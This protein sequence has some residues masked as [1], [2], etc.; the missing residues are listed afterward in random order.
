MLQVILETLWFFLPAMVANMAPVFVAKYK[1][2]E[3]LNYSIDG[4]ATFRGK[5]LFGD[6]KTVR[7]FVVGVAIALLTG[8]MQYFLFQYE[9]VT[10]I[11]IMSYSSILFVLGVSFLLGFGALVGD[12]IKSFFK[13]QFNILPGHSWP[14]FDQI[15]FVIGASFFTLVITNVS[16][17]HIITAIILLGTASYIV[18][19]IGVLTRVKRTI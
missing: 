16:Y 1:L 15:D 10:N 6:H 18:S 14:V 4:G 12:A 5:R 8:G 17:V 3:S 19:V 7:G 9:Y 2:L 11:S 13:R